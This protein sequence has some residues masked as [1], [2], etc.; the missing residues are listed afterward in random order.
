[1]RLAESM[2]CA[3]KYPVR[4]LA[5]ASRCFLTTVLTALASHRAHIFEA[6]SLLGIWRHWLSISTATVCNSMKW[7]DRSDPACS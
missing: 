3:R 1:M 6:V 5:V 2:G 4:L 7:P